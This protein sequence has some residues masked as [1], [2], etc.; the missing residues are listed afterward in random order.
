MFFF[1][2]YVFRLFLGPIEVQ[3]IFMIMAMNMLII[4]IMFQQIYI[5]N[6]V[7]DSLCHHGWCHRGTSIE[8]DHDASDLL[9]INIFTQAC[10]QTDKLYP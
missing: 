1:Q 9:N 10:F 8:T 6:H 3:I 5:T 2:G 7:S 4:E